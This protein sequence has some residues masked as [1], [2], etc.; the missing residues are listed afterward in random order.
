[1]SSC[2]RLTSFRYELPYIAL[3][4]LPRSSLPAVGSALRNN[5]FAPYIPC[6]RVIASSLYIGGF[7]GEWGPDSKTKTQYHRKVAI[8]KEE[9]V[10]F[11]E[12]GYLQEKERVWKDNRKI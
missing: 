3:V 8:L 4:V 5:P 6:H 12:K 9:G 1:M 11:T 10:K 2:W 7:V